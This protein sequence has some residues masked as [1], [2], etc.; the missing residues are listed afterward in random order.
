MSEFDT[1]NGVVT[2]SSSVSLCPKCKAFA[3]ECDTPIGDGAETLCWLCAHD[4]VHHGAAL[5]DGPGRTCGCAKT[6]VYPAWKL[7]EIATNAE[8][9]RVA[10]LRQA[11]AELGIPEPEDTTVVDVPFVEAPR[12]V[13]RHSERALEMKRGRVAR[14]QLHRTGEHPTEN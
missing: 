12:F 9:G 6:D 2:M 3:A 14:V 13:G 1:I 5:E 4:V 10:F 7:A 8:A 11:R